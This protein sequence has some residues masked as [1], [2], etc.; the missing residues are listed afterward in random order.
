MRCLVTGARGLLGSELVRF[1][2]AHGD[3]IIGWDLPGHDVTAVEETINGIHRV[4]PEII[5]HLAAWTDVDGCEKDRGR[6][7][8]VNYQGTWAVALGAAELGC[9]LLYVSTDYVF[10][11]TKQRPY[12]ED[13][14][15]RPL[16]V[17]GRTKLMGEQAVVKT[18]KHSF[19]VRTSWLYG[20][21]G[22]N[23]VNRIIE[24]AR[25]QRQLRVVDDQTGSPTW[26]RD[27]CA[28]LRRI[29]TSTRFGIYHVTNSG[30]CT[31]LE[32]AQEA[33]RLARIECELVP[34]SSADLNLPAARP[35]YSVLDNRNYRR[36]TGEQLR[37]WQD[38]LCEYLGSPGSQ[39]G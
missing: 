33:L 14:V 30:S 1:L 29:A 15:P 35:A 39:V 17:Y 5:Y 24:S 37:P 23:F 9:R 3:Q 38:A 21:N 2:K 26:A 31:W 10:D 19:V 12:R 22:R 13:D 16:S 7:A 34:V 6:A 27:I 36:L 8:A 20:S 18:C 28:A 4:G 11:G 32:L 25:E